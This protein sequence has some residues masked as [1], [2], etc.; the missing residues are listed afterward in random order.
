MMKCKECGKIIKKNTWAYENISGDL[1]CC[2][3]C[4][5]EKSN[6]LVFFIGDE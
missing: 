6:K 3:I 2:A 5:L 4:Y 1:Y